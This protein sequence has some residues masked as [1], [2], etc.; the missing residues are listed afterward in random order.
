MPAIISQVEGL[1]KSWENCTG[2]RIKAPPTPLNTV[3]KGVQPC[4]G[5]QNGGGVGSLLL[6]FKS[7]DGGK[8]ETPG[9]RKREWEPKLVWG[10][11]FRELGMPWKALSSPLSSGGQGGAEIFF[12]RGERGRGRNWGGRH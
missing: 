3:K 12:L 8:E 4:R 10:Y 5:R 6:I 2:I 7:L 1:E 11:Y 9:K